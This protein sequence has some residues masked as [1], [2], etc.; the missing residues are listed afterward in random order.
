GRAARAGGG[1][2]GAAGAPR[3]G[4]HHGRERHARRRGSRRHARRAAPMSAVTELLE[5]LVSIPSVTGDEQAIC[6]F[7]ATRLRSGG[8]EVT[9][10]DR[11]LAC[12]VRAKS[13]GPVLL[14]SS[15]TDVVPPGEG[16]TRAPFEPHRDGFRLVGRGANDAKASVASMAVAMQALAGDATH[17]GGGG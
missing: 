8:L 7:L 6:A 16:W 2:T 3:R 17:A 5:E 14:L 11:N 9:V 13:P 4:P 1:R 15:H 12:R 10:S